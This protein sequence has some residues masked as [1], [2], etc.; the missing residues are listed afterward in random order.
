MDKKDRNGDWLTEARPKGP[1]QMLE[2]LY[3]I[4]S[5]IHCSDHSLK[6][7]ISNTL[8]GIK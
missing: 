6:S 8:M 4:Q 1:F 7:I 3:L 5:Q 2:L